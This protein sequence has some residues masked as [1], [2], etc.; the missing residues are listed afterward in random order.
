MC[1]SF[2]HNCM[3]STS[4]EH[5]VAIVALVVVVNTNVSIGVKGLLFEC[6]NNKYPII[7][8][9]KNT[10]NRIHTHT[11]RSHSFHHSCMCNTPN[12]WVVSIVV[13]ILKLTLMC[14]Y[15]SRV[16]YLSVATTNII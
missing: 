13:S 10:Q 2:H 3:C 15:V 6:S 1:C 4:N 9:R 16:F 14:L 8:Y 12:E 5:F 7:I 11:Q